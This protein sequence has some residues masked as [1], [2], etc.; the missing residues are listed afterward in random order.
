MSEK[1]YDVFLSYSHKDRPWVTEFVSALETS[2]VKT[3]SDADIAPGER[4]QEKMQEALR[5][6]ST[7]IMVL[8]PNNTQSHWMFFELGAAIG[9]EKRIIPILLNE[10]DIG[11]IPVAL[12]QFQALR[13]S[14]PQE[15]GKRVAEV[16]DKIQIH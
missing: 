6:S 11:R 14:S 13:E 8:S 12:R 3:W 1:H 7:L 5:E 16:L 10:L 15:A 4:W 2:G 9:G